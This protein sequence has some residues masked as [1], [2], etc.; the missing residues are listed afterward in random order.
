LH[1]GH[2]TL[3]LNQSA[4]LDLLAQLK[5]T[6]VNDSIYVAAEKLYEELIGAEARVLIGGVPVRAQH[7]P[8]RHSP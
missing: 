1:E 3:A 5:L 6:D 4:L 8:Q 2:H 7:P